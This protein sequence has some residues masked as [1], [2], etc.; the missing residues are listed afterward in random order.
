L[1]VESK[2][3]EKLPIDVA[4]P[5]RD[6]RAPGGYSACSATMGSTRVARRAGTADAARP[7]TTST[8]TTPANVPGSYGST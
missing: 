8:A 3:I 4:P 5:P 1:A 6:A 7:V 2:V